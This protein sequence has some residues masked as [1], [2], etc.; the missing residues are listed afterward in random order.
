MGVP[1]TSALRLPLLSGLTTAAATAV[2]AS[3]VSRWRLGTGAALLAY[4]SPD[5]SV[6]SATAMALLADV[7]VTAFF[8]M[9]L[10][11][12]LGDFV[13]INEIHFFFLI[14]RFLSF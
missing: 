12:S 13:T 2:Q 6:S 7:L 9:F 11:A 4:H 14:R 3:V 5:R 10:I 1:T 8:F